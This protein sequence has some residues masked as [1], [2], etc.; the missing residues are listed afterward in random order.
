MSDKKRPFQ[1]DDPRGDVGYA[2]S[3]PSTVPTTNPQGIKPTPVLTS[4]GFGI[5]NGIP[6]G[7]NLARAERAFDQAHKMNP[8]RRD[9]LASAT[10]RRTGTL[11]PTVA[12]K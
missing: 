6:Y 11:A 10:R 3:P 9:A 12:P 5:V 1:Q 4:E 8:A 7:T 2:V